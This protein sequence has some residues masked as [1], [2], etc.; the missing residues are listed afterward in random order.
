MNSTKILL[1]LYKD[2]K[3]HE[4]FEIYSHFDSIFGFCDTRRNKI[5]RGLQQNLKKQGI[6][7]NVGYATWQLVA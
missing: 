2:G 5:L 6:L 7:K 3:P 1:E 4:N